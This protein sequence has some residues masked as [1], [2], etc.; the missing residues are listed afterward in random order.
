MSY[1]YPGIHSHPMVVLQLQLHQSLGPPQSKFLSSCSCLVPGP[2]LAIVSGPAP[3]S[4]CIQS[5]T[6]ILYVFLPMLI[7]LLWSV[8]FPNLDSNSI[9]VSSY[10]A[11][12][13]LASL[14]L[15]MPAGIT[16]T[17]A[18]LYSGSFLCTV[19]FMSPA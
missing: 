6:S 9:N 1:A 3:I 13:E 16:S 5:H 11:S 14:T 12:M 18:F 2:A 8:L 19:S 7:I 17:C 4:V 15:G 10:P